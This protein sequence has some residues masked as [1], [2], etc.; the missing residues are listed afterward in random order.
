MMVVTVDIYIWYIPGEDAMFISAEESVKQFG[1][2]SKTFC[3]S[4]DWEYYLTC[5][6]WANK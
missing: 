3:L 5:W 2:G 6:V 4:I 1:S